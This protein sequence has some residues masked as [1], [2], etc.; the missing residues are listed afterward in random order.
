MCKMPAPAVIHW[1]AAVLDDAAAA[2]GVLVQERAVDHVRHGL[3]TAVGVP[4]GALGFARAVVDLAHL[5]HV[6]EGIEV[7]DVDAG[8]GAAHRE[9]LAL[10]AAR[11][12]RD[13]LDAAGSIC[14]GLG[15]QDFGSSS[16]F[17]TEMAGMTSA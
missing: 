10:E 1:V 6:D 4:R 2:D 9:P 17:S 8:E 15:S 11:R 7:G 16:G 13:R 5:V 12:G 14:L 3:E